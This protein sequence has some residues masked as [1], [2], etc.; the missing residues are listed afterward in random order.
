[1]DSP[2][3]KD[4]RF[5]VDDNYRNI[6][7]TV[8]DTGKESSKT[9][10]QTKSTLK[11]DSNSISGNIVKPDTLPSI[12]E[13][14][15]NYIQYAEAISEFILNPNTKTPI[16][17]AI[18]GEWG[19]GKS[20]LMTWIRELLIE[21][22]MPTVWYNAWKHPNKEAVW[23][24]FF[25]EL[26]CQVEQSVKFLK[27]KLWIER[28][29]NY[30][31]K[32]SLV[33][34]LFVS[35]LFMLIY[36]LAS[37]FDATFL[38]ILGIKGLTKAD[39]I[40]VFSGFAA[41]LFGIMF[42]YKTVPL[43]NRH[44]HNITKLADGPDYQLKLGFQGSFEKDLEYIIKLTTKENPLVIFIDDLDRV[45]PDNI[46]SMLDAIKIITSFEKCV[47]VLGIDPVLVGASIESNYK[48]IIETIKEKDKSVAD[49]F[50]G[51]FIEKLIQI[52]FRIPAISSDDVKSYLNAIT[53][54][55][56]FNNYEKS[57]KRSNLPIQ[58]VV[59]NDST[60]FIE[61]VKLRVDLLPPN[62]R[63]IK[64]FVN[65]FR[66]M[67]NIAEKR[68]LITKGDFYL[69]EL[70]AIVIAATEHNFIYRVWIHGDKS[71][72]DKMV[73]DAKNNADDL[74]ETEHADIKTIKTL[75]YQERET[76]NI[77]D[78]IENKSLYIN[79]SSLVET[80]IKS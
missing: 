57:P 80:K 74:Q 66:L 31:V 49:K 3:Q 38:D 7:E 64:R 8:E 76:I 22:K 62:P 52:S 56:D 72:W 70:A 36:Y 34:S 37:Y 35:I 58:I 1:M 61:A 59:K 40:A 4:T 12:D 21:N 48:N 19:S 29:K 78:S 32:A 15:L 20:T 46:T 30:N 53:N 13:D 6:A 23:A 47:F 5:N 55:K 41:S 54:I 63:K 75:S 79:L 45:S 43:F 16:T 14:A 77:L 51:N 67:V 60:E 73:K 18:S 27:Y 2:E 24:G 50:G 71:S 33:I 17:I 28:A 39:S 68:D 44:V 10:K 9:R 11:T 69:E 65:Y 42:L 25:Q 26:F